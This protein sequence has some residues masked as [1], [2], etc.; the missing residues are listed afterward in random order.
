MDVR[1]H[2]LTGPQEWWGHSCCWGP[3]PPAWRQASSAVMS[4]VC[5]L[6]REGASGCFPFRRH[7]SF[8]PWHPWPSLALSPQSPL[9][10]APMS[11]ALLQP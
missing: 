1:G 7:C 8:S 5:R 11:A 3:A 9:P 6:H 4:P 2:L 10:V